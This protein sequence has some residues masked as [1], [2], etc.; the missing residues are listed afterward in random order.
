MRDNSRN[1]EWKVGQV[2]F[3]DNDK[4]FGFVE[5]WD[6]G[7]DYF[8]HISKVDTEPIDDHDYVVFKLGQSRK[9]PG[10]YEV[11]NLSLASKFSQD[12]AYIKAQFSKYPNE[13]FRKNVLQ[14]LPKSDIVNLLEQE[15]TMFKSIDSDE[16][17]ADFN[18]VIKFY[19]SLNTN[20]SLQKGIYSIISAWVDQIA[21]AD[22]KINFWL[23]GVLST[24]P[25]EE[26]LR[27]YFK[28]SDSSKRL[29]IFKRLDNSAK[30]ELIQQYL[31]D[32]EPQEVIDF[33]LEHLKQINELGYYADVKSKLY[34]A[35]YW[36]DKTDYDLYEIVIEH[37]QETLNEKEKL[38]LFLSGY[39]NSISSDFI[40]ETYLE[41]P[42]EEIEQILEREVLSK[43]EAF[44]LVD[45]L[46]TKEIE[47]FWS[48][49]NIPDQE[50]V[51]TASD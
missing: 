39:L 9:K 19:S 46:L 29:E 36:A 33:V 37:L 1:T 47:H 14:S 51:N 26:I 48:N 11:R 6:D 31:S 17:Y 21:S 43:T 16:Q 44:T 8:V 18:K 49:D 42:R 10:T 23:D 27:S 12:T 38:S 5:C 41:L 28:T 20:E 24:Q 4:G 40:L 32:G 15:I 2:K 50:F 3:F 22:F 7:Q 35:E 25:E 45:K 30:T 13:Y 34:E